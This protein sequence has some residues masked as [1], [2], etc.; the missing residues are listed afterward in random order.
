MK[1]A[2]TAPTLDLD[3][4]VE[5]K[6]RGFGRADNSQNLNAG[7]ARGSRRAGTGWNPV[8]KRCSGDPWNPRLVALEAAGMNVYA[9]AS[10]TVA[11]AIKRFEAGELKRQDQ[12]DIEEQW[13]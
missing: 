4:V 8:S 7:Q 1:M 2:I 9:G 12:A 13:V 10:G 3:A 11:E 6:R 5:T